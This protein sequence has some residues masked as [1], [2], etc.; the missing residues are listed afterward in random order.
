[1]LYTKTGIATCI[2]SDI[3]Y[4]VTEKRKNYARNASA[5][6]YWKLTFTL[7]IIAHHCMVIIISK[8]VVIYNYNF[9]FA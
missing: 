7:Q 3:K 9:C 5:K 4:K 2:G 1:M 6:N 8:T